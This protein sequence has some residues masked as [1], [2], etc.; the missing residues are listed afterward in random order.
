MKKLFASII[1]FV[2]ISYAQLD[3]ITITPYQDV[4]LP[5]KPIVYYPATGLKF[6]KDQ[7]KIE[8]S[9]KGGNKPTGSEV[10]ILVAEPLKPLK[11]KD[12]NNQFGVP[13]SCYAKV[14]FNKP[15]TTYYVKLDASADG[16]CDNPIS[17]N[18]PNRL[19]VGKNEFIVKVEYP[20]MALELD[21]DSLAY[22]IGVDKSAEKTFY[23]EGLPA[24]YKDTDSSH[25]LTELRF[26]LKNKGKDTTVQIFNPSVKFSN[27]I[28]SDYVTDSGRVTVK[29]GM[30]KDKEIIQYKKDKS[31]DTV[32]TASWKFNIKFPE[33]M[34]YQQPL[35]WL[36][37]EDWVLKSTPVLDLTKDEDRIIGIAFDGGPNNP[38]L[39]EIRAA[40]E[41]RT[42]VENLIQSVTQISNRSTNYLNIV[43]PADA[44]S[45]TIENREVILTVNLTTKQGAEIKK[46]FKAIVN[47]KKP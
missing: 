18:V 5:L 41:L 31:G 27:F 46:R 10:L 40:N 32:F 1:I 11:S 42:N 4:N 47:Y 14:R 20:K 12:N 26:Y 3:T 38:I 17:I 36:P 15:G 23:F 39:P 34:I 9:G 45:S 21:V 33:R 8:E 43:I 16:N 13:W 28:T 24:K 2:S 22:T 29:Y 6:G 37:E 35:K 30:G 25:Y 19:M 44:L 7:V